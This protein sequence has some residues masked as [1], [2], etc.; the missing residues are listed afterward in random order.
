MFIKVMKL[1]YKLVWDLFTASVV[2]VLLWILLTIRNFPDAFGLACRTVPL[3]I[4][5]F[6]GINRLFGSLD[7]DDEAVL[8]QMLPIRKKTCLTV[9]LL[10]TGLWFTVSFTAMALVGYISCRLAYRGID[11]LQE[12]LADM[13]ESGMS[14][15]QADML[16]AAFPAVVFLLICFVCLMVVAVQLLGNAMGSR[17]KKVFGIMMLTLIGI[18]AALAII[19]AVYGIVISIMRTSS[20]KAAF[21]IAAG[22]AVLMA[23]VDGLLYLGTS[24]L[25]EEKYEVG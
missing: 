8:M 1:H 11:P 9:K 23:A 18:L 17:R 19:W 22:A 25:L 12:L 21:S 3:I 13:T 24:R 20:P 4:V 16:A 7:F 15:M 6:L 10:M 2:A 14:G 5:L